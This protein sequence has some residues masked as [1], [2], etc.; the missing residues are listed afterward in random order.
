MSSDYWR[1][2]NSKCFLCSQFVLDGKLILNLQTNLGMIWGV[3]WIH[4]YNCR[5]N[6]Q[7][8][9]FVLIPLRNILLAW[10]INFY[11]KN[12]LFLY[13]KKGDF[14]LLIWEKTCLTSIQMTRSFKIQMVRLFFM[15]M[16]MLRFSCKNCQFLVIRLIT[17]LH[18]STIS[19]RYL[20]F[21]N[22]LFLQP[23][24]PYQGGVFFLTINFPTDYPFKPPKAS[25]F[26]LLWSLF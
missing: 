5:C 26:F 1:F 3:L 11:F 25:S 2:S 10:L 24:S 9:Y 22:F 13:K 20:K 19:F 17:P 14:V 21:C 16:L 7:G 4:T 8:G 15:K 6:E 12:H 23:D 18:F